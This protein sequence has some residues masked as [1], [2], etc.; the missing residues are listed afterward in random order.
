M[1]GCHKPSICKTQYL[2]SAI[3]QK[4]SNK[5][6]YVCTTLCVCERE[7]WESMTQWEPSERIKLPC[8][9][10]PS[11]RKTWDWPSNASDYRR[12][13]DS[14]SVHGDVFLS[15]GIFAVGKNRVLNMLRAAWRPGQCFSG[16]HSRSTNLHVSLLGGG[17]WVW[18]IKAKSGAEHC[19]RGCHKLVFAFTLSLTL[20]LFLRWNST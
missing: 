19:S 9:S 16:K 3:K 20:L 18:T 13:N 15:F 17:R 11:L 1:Q 4:H 10:F 14:S 7:R 5:M 2:Q 12:D 8:F 6:R